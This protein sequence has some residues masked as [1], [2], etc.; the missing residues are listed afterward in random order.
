MIIIETSIPIQADRKV[1][2]ISN[3]P[4]GVIAKI[5]ALKSRQG[6]KEMPSGRCNYAVTLSSFEPQLS[7]YLPHECRLLS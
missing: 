6:A 5:L 2:R 1:F 3:S 7:H 4:S